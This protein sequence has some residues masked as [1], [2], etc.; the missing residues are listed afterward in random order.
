MKYSV[1]YFAWF[2]CIVFETWQCCNEFSASCMYVCM[3]PIA[4]GQMYSKSDFQ[5]LNEILET[6][7]CDRRVGGNNLC[8]VSS[9]LPLSSPK[10]TSCCKL[11]IQRV[12][13][14]TFYRYLYM[15]TNY[16]N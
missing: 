11:Y 10:L 12:I 1:M 14:F 13:V 5:A 9:F 4:A 7:C 16:W 6:G 15:Q 2:D 3:H 8:L